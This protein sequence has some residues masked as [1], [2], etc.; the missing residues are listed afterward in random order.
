MPKPGKEEIQFV[1]PAHWYAVEWSDKLKKEPVKK[2]VAGKDIVLFRGED[3]TASAISAYCPHRGADLSLGFCSDGGVRC[4]YHGWLF[5]EDGTCTHIPAHPDRP[6]PDSAHATCYPVLERAGLIWVYPSEKPHN[7]LELYSELEDPSFTL[8]PYQSIWK[9]HI[10]RVVESVLDATHVPMIH[11]KTIGKNSSPEVRFQ[12][13]ADGDTIWIKN[14]NAQLEYQ[15]P[16]HWI[17]RTR[18]ERKKRFINYVTFTPIDDKHTAIMG[19]VGR[20]F[21]KWSVF[22][23]FFS[24]YSCK[25]LK[26]DQEIVERQHPHY[27][28]EALQM[29]VH[30]PADGPQ[31]HFR[32]RW[33]HFLTKN[34]PKLFSSQ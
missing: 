1:F 9:A 33:Y 5:Q 15:F 24:S 4:A 13:Q 8:A 17:L 25:I 27:V 32:N 16:Q 20:N 11:C 21:L 30:V 23:K 12:F 18:Q 29:E 10:T 31:V 6:I 28:P 3:G 22:N 34:E 14:G 26:E 2:K 19:Y 7:E